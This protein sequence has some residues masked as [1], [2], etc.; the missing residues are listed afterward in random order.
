MDNILYW[1]QQPGDRM[2][3]VPDLNSLWLFFDGGVG[4]S[5][6]LV[7]LVSLLKYVLKDLQH[8]W[9]LKNVERLRIIADGQSSRLTRVLHGNPFYRV[10][11]SNEFSIKLTFGNIECLKY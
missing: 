3:K 2:V 11:V 10:E 4:D 9:N 6:T 7:N 8:S 1:L 5:H